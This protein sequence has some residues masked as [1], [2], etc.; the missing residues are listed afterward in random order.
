MSENKN[1]KVTIL[2]KKSVEA[3]NY[4]ATKKKNAKLKPMM[5]YWNSHN[6]LALNPDLNIISIIHTM[7]RS[8]EAIQ[9]TF[10][11]LKP[12][13]KFEFSDILVA[14][15]EP[16]SSTAIGGKIRNAPFVNLSIYYTFN[17][18]L[19][20]YGELLLTYREFS[21]SLS[22]NSKKQMTEQSEE[23]ANII[24][25]QMGMIQQFNA[26]FTGIAERLFDCILYEVN[27][28]EKKTRF[29]EAAIEELYPKMIAE[30]KDPTDL[31]DLHLMLID[32]IV[33]RYSEVNNL[34]Q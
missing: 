10:K 33:D 17:N 4:V 22:K 7:K 24:S 12:N 23:M 27:V 34:K 19:L 15:N 31:L 9:K 26:Q 29:K 5:E 6:D 1:N 25:N 28:F 14:V 2:P 3:A 20:Q 30:Y 32:K 18:H 8:I 11:G 13:Q 21:K 16:L